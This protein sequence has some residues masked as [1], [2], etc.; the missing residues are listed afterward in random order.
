M[1]RWRGRFSSPPFA[2]ISSQKSLLP[3][4]ER[5][6]ARYGIPE[7][8]EK[9]RILTSVKDEVEDSAVEQEVGDEEDGQ[10]NGNWE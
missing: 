5:R 8:L 6:S 3:L 7:G 10:G 2:I 9:L 4:F 1:H